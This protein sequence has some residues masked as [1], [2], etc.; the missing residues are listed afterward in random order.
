MGDVELG[1][2]HYLDQKEFV[3]LCMVIGTWIDRKIICRASK[4]AEGTDCPECL[5]ALAAISGTNLKDN[6]D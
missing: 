3:P 5:T 2:I 1:V 4:S 6:H